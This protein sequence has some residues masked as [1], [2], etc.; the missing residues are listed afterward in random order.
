MPKRTTPSERKTSSRLFRSM[1]LSG[2]KQAH[3]DTHELNDRRNS[4]ISVSDSEKVTALTDHNVQLMDERNEAVDECSRIKK[5]LED[6]NMKLKGAEQEIENLNAL[7]SSRIK[8]EFDNCDLNPNDQ[9]TLISDLSDVPLQ[10][11]KDDK[12]NVIFPSKVEHLETTIEA[13]AVPFYKISHCK[14]CDRLKGLRIK[15]VVEAIAL[16]KYVKNL[17]DALS[18]GDAGKQKFLQ[19]VERKLTA[20][21]TEK[22]V[23]LEELANVVDHRNQAVLEKDR[24]IEEWGKAQSKWENTLDQVDSLMKE[25]N[26]VRSAFVPH[27]CM[28]KA[29]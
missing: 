6:A 4:T 13:N 26:Q 28:R 9:R 1:S 18:G 16:R 29:T 24:A 23:A 15:A 22:E 3:K 19:D 27:A 21:Q 8:Q 25:L 5:D 7:L 11:D 10:E 2:R 17:N 14:E 12:N 20:A